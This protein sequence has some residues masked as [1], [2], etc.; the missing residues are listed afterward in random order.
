MLLR[1]CRYKHI[2]ML[3][4]LFQLYAIKVGNGTRDSYFADRNV[5]VGG[6]VQS[7]DD[8]NLMKLTIG[9]FFKESAMSF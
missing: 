6:G 8:R 4:R 2:V 9:R 3:L 1:P 5:Y 7:D